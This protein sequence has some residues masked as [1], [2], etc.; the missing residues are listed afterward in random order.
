MKI[1]LVSAEAFPFSKTG[2][3]GDV[4]GS[5]FKELLRANQDVSLFLPYYRSTRQKIGSKLVNCNLV[6]GVPIGRG[7]KFGAVLSARAHSTGSQNLELEPDQRGNVFFIEH[8]DYFDRDQLYGTQ[9]GDFFDNAERFIFFSRAILEICK[10]LGLRFNIIHCHDWHTSLIPLY[11]RTL[12]KECHCFERVKSVLTIHNLGYQGV[13]PRETLELTGFGWEMFHIDGLEF[14]GMVNFLKGGIFNAD[15]ITTVSPTYAREITLADYGF[16]LHGVLRKRYD[17]LR[18]ILNGIDYELWNPEQDCC[19]VKNYSKH[20]LEDKLVNK[21]HLLL[22]AGLDG[23]RE[24][25]L[26]GFIGR[27]VSQKGIDILIDS[28]GHIVDRGGRIVFIG[29]G[30]AYFEGR[31]RQLMDWFPGKVATFIVYDE[32]LAHQVY[33]GVDALIMPSKYEPCGLS[34]LIAMRYGTIPICRKT[35]GLA[36]TVEDGITGILFDDFSSEALKHAIDRFLEIYG[37]SQRFR[38]MIVQ[39]MERDFSWDRMIREYIRLYEEILNQ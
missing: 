3:L 11:L 32:E 23:D 12:Y 36:D 18:G 20:N 1:A 16:G 25:P 24:A 19:I 6:Y 28:V 27:M 39:A 15:M 33:A 4:V 26:F 17:S 37:D 35:G 38:E 30:D 31:V 8:N 29:T 13:F 7:M 5:L 22:K 10:G 34:Q 2:G 14:Y 21:E 9:F